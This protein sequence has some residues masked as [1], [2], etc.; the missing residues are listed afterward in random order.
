MDRYNINRFK[1][2]E[3]M[4]DEPVPRGGT[5]QQRANTFSMAGRTQFTEDISKR[6]PKESNP[7]EM[8]KKWENKN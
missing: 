4:Q 8:R 3:E 2:K 6:K 7:L 1:N 5:N